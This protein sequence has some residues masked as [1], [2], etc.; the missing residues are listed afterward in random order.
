M[1]IEWKQFETKESFSQNLLHENLTVAH[2]TMHARTSRPYLI[3]RR[4]LTRSLQP[5]A[6]QH[7]LP[8]TAVPNLPPFYPA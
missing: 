4:D 6:L 7:A 5:I 2:W 1:D 8:P 3:G